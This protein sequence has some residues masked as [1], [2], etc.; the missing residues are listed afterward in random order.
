MKESDIIDI[1][2]NSDLLNGLAVETKTE[3]IRRQLYQAFGLQYPDLEYSAGRFIPTRKSA[4]YPEDAIDVFC[5]AANHVEA[6]SAVHAGRS[7]TVYEKTFADSYR[8]V[9]AKDFAKCKFEP[10]FYRRHGSNVLVP[11]YSD[12]SVVGPSGEGYPFFTEAQFIATELEQG[13][14]VV[15]HDYEGDDAVSVDLIHFRKDGS[16]CWIQK[17]KGS[18]PK[19]PLLWVGALQLDHWH[20]PYTAEEAATQ[21]DTELLLCSS[22]RAPLIAPKLFD[23]FD[24]TVRQ[25]ARL[26]AGY[27]GIASFTK[28]DGTKLIELPD[29]GYAEF[30][31]SK[32]AIRIE[33]NNGRKARGKTHTIEV[34]DLAFSKLLA[35]AMKEIPSWKPTRH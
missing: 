2:S 11:G 20:A 3:E 26:L 13:T 10:V 33:I 17:V 16:S 31:P 21:E 34:G 22:S 24:L 28:E 27:F 5:V 32:K 6:T 14:S 8:K 30:T 35:T 25:K 7:V 23:E 15:F 12:G 18:T 19:E 9:V 4:A 29:D 1:I